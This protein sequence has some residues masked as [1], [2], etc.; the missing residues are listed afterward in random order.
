VSDTR[1]IV[2]A[3]ITTPSRLGQFGD[4]AK[5]HV[6]FE[7]SDTEELLFSYFHDEI[8]FTSQELIGLTVDEAEQLRH[9]K[10]VAYL[11]S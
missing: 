11:R 8:S 4:M 7:N 3:R 9:K 1:K 10:D 5:I 6:K 2:S